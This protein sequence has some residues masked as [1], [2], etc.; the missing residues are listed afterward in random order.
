MKYYQYYICVDGTIEGKGYNNPLITAKDILYK[1]GKYG[2]IKVANIY[3]FVSDNADEVE[4]PESIKTY[5]QV[6][7]IR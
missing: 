3:G 5:W 2:I 4:L 1:D 6:L 7:N